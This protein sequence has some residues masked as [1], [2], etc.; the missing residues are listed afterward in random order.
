LKQLW[1]MRPST[2]LRALSKGVVH[3]ASNVFTAERDS[4]SSRQFRHTPVM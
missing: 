3:D 2:P 4:P 1:K